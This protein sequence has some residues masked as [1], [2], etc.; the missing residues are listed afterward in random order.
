MSRIDDRSAIAP[1]LIGEVLNTASAFGD[2]AWFDKLVA[3][4]KVT[5]D[6]A[7][8]QALIG[9]LGQFRDPSIIE[10]TFGLL[11]KDDFDIRRTVGLL[12]GPLGYWKT[13]ELPYAWVKQNYDALAARLPRVV[14]SDMTAILPFTATGACSAKSA[15]DAEAFF[16]DKMTKAVGGPRTLAQALESIRL[17]AARREAQQAGL[18]EFLKSY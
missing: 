14:E 3:A 9:A 16:K 17:C 8:G 4:A 13:R 5:Q 12:F 1:E 15:A 10:S 18:A 2:R 11:L 7:E 6:P